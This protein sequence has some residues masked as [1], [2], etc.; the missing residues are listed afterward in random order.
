M[1]VMMREG[2]AKEQ[3]QLQTVP[4][5]YIVS[6]SMIGK[7]LTRQ[8]GTVV[9]GYH[10]AEY[11]LP[12]GDKLRLIANHNQSKSVQI[13][14][15][16]HYPDKLNGL[17]GTNACSLVANVIQLVNDYYIKSLMYEVKGE[18][19]KAQLKK[20]RIIENA[21]ASLQCLLGRERALPKTDIK[22][23]ELLRKDLIAILERARDDNRYVSDS[24]TVSEGKLNEIL[25]YAAHE[26]AAEFS[27]NQNI[28]ISRRDQ[29]DMSGLFNADEIENSI[30]RD[31]F[32]RFLQDIELSP[33]SIA[34]IND[35]FSSTT[36]W[37]KFNKEA[38]AHLFSKSG[39]FVTHPQMDAT[40]L[41]FMLVE[42]KERY[43]EMKGVHRVVQLPESESKII[44]D[45]QYHIGDDQQELDKALFMIC[46]NYN[47]SCPKQMPLYEGHR[48]LRFIK[49]F[50]N[51][52]KN[53]QKAAD[54]FALPHKPASRTQQRVTEDGLMVRRTDP[55]YELLG[56]KQEM[57]PTLHALAQALLG[58]HFQQQAS[59]ILIHD[60]EPQPRYVENPV[61]PH[62]I[63]EGRNVL[64]IASIGEYTLVKE[65][66][67]AYQEPRHFLLIKVDEGKY[68][69]QRYQNTNDDRVVPIPNGDDLYEMANLARKNIY[70]PERFKIKAQ[71]FFTSII[72]AF[73]RSFRSLKRFVVETIPDMYMHQVHDGHIKDDGL[74]A[75]FKAR[76]IQLSD[77]QVNDFNLFLENLSVYPVCKHLE[78]NPEVEGDPLFQYLSFHV[79]LYLENHCSID[80]RDIEDLFTTMDG[81]LAGYTAKK[82]RELHQEM[83]GLEKARA[84][85]V[86]IEKFLRGIH[87]LPNGMNL[88]EFIHQELER[89][90]FLLAQPE[91]EPDTFE[92]TNPINRSFRVLRKFTH[93]FQHYSEKNPL[94][95]TLAIAAYV[96]G[97]MAV[98]APNT[99]SAILAKLHLHG[100]IKAIKPTQDFAKL[101]GKGMV[102][103]AISA[104]FTYWQGVIVGGDIDKFFRLA[105]DLVKDDPVELAVVTAL[106]VGLGYTMCKA[107]PPLAEEIGTVPWPSYAT[108][109]AKGGAAMYDMVHNPGEDFITGTLKWV[110]GII[111][112]MGQ[113]VSAPFVEWGKYGF[114]EGFLPGLKKSVFA[115]GR[116]LKQ[117]SAALGTLLLSIASL[118][119]NEIPAWCLHIPFRGVTKLITKTLA[120]LGDWKGVGDQLIGIA[121]R[122]ASWNYFEGFRLSP[123]YGF[124]NPFK[125]YAQNPILNVGA[126][127]A[128]AV[129]S[130]VKDIIKNVAVLPAID[131]TSLAIRAAMTVVI[132]PVVRISAGFVGGIIKGAGML[133]DPTV[134]KLF[135]GLAKGVIKV[136]DGIDRVCGRFKRWA[137]SKINMGK[138][139]LKVWA[140]GAD[141]LNPDDK[142]TPEEKHLTQKP[143]ELAKLTGSQ[144]VVRET[145]MQAPIDE[146]DKGKAPMREESSPLLNRVQFSS[147]AEF[148]LLRGRTAKNQ[149]RYTLPPSDDES[150]SLIEKR[151]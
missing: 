35:Y 135:R 3:V 119:V 108:L 6:P 77:Q 95:G 24:A 143:M 13:I 88:S 19:T 12:G 11:I 132:N 5:R 112:F 138:S 120:T 100:L 54:Y 71:A 66:G 117:A 104:G 52:W 98:V 147:S 139:H 37:P 141:K 17:P 68:I 32:G 73:K 130:P 109:G 124:N 56:T 148:A 87:R 50:D 74:R 134:G 18:L 142:K 58:K 67:P 110:L 115:T 78:E 76:N 94:I 33:R 131:L 121:T 65:N 150:L 28:E 106:A 40:E 41:S 27:F 122:K 83:E 31:I 107:I 23:Q 111:A 4:Y 39:G 8:G 72:P 113:A 97:G 93:F 80:S 128:M 75:Y 46:H 140:Y 21:I 125:R 145:V 127:I 30:L 96:Y 29:L 99:L 86:N 64:D 55:S 36:E 14:L 81:G 20:R 69:C 63:E 61:A 62:T 70:W 102:S 144:A 136:A 85:V 123:M 92:F 133:W 116:H 59:P 10:C 44:W 47:I 43:A 146:D 60:I 53:A 15:E 126:N 90:P 22:G 82:R 38:I 34:R 9:Y 25:Y 84:N 45:S 149:S 151:Y 42:I 7:A 2:V 79:A 118:L 16:T 1:R 57:Y 103:E 51:L 26:Y 91:H 105:V 114:R 49:Y 129:I 137:L 101:M 89:D 48:L